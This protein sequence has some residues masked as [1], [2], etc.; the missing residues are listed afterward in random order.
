MELI[1]HENPKEK[2]PQPVWQP[3][4]GKAKRSFKE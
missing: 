4:K 2:T 1:K 3:K